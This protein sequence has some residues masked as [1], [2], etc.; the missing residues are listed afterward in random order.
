VNGAKVEYYIYR[1]RYYQP[2]WA[3]EDD[4][5]GKDDSH[6]EDAS[7]YGYDNDMVKN[8]EGRLDSSGKLNVEFTVPQPDAKQLW[9]Y[10]YRLE[11][12]VTDSSRRTNTASASFVGIR[13]NIVAT[14]AADKY[15]Y[16]TGDTAKVRVRTSDYTGKPVSSKVQLKFVSRTYKRIEK[17][18]DGY[19]RVEY[20]PSDTDLS[21]GRLQR[22]LRVRQST[23]FAPKNR[24]A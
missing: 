2:W 23:N 24:A 13:G 17:D 6:E 10:T 12:Q 11:A 9:D 20:Q 5:I 22:M 21:S 3:E 14:A 7:G 18:E 19:K 15:V 1:S 16:F 4:G 8:G